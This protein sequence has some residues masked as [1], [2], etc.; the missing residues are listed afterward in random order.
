MLV[1]AV[2]RVSCRFSPPFF[3][4]YGTEEA[5]SKV[6]HVGFLEAKCAGTVVTS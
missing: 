5:S 3:Y 4:T 1:P 2:S 6:Q